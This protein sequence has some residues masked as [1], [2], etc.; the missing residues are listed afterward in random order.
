MRNIRQQNPN[1]F[2]Q[3]C[4]AAI[5][6]SVVMTSYNR[7][8]YKITSI[9]WNTKVTDNFTITRKD[10]SRQTTFKD[11]FEKKGVTLQQMGQPLLVSSPSARDIRRGDTGDKLLPP[12]MCYQTGL[13]DDMRANFRLM[14][15]LAIH[16]HQPPPQRLS[17]CTQFVERMKENDAV[18][19]YFIC[20]ITLHS[21]S[22]KFLI[23][24]FFEK[25]V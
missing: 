11:Y 5:V 19:N 8:T 21:Y 1:T 17:K 20:S 3:S 25:L 24:Y 4:E 23:L 12:E 15:D 6:G 16:L 13:N 22:L 10:I 2:R 7:R 14:K 9:D 18:S